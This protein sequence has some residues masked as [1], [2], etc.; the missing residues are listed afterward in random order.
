MGMPSIFAPLYRKSSGWV[1]G[2]CAGIGEV[3]GVR[4]W[5]LRISLL[6]AVYLFPFYALVGYAALGLI[7]GARRFLV[8]DTP[9][10]DE[11]TSDERV[12]TE[13]YSVHDRYRD[14]EMRLTSLESEALSKET[15]LRRRFREAGL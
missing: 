12:S 8:G 10:D 1:L 4:P 7:F 11:W 5:I 14:L 3:V 2:V 6:L 13:P 9:S 15:D